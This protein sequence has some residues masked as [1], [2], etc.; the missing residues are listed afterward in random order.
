MEQIQNETQKELTLQEIQ[1]GSFQVLLKIKEICEKENIKYFLMY[2]TL[3]GAIRH[4][5]FI[6]WD[7]DIDVGMLRA[8]YERFIQYC[9]DHKE[10]IKPFELMHYRTNKKYIYP[11]AR[12]SDSRYRIEYNDAKDYGLGLFVDI[13]PFDKID[14]NDKRLIKEGKKRI[15]WICN[16]GCKH[17]IRSKNP[18]KTVLKIPF[19]IM[20]RFINLNKLLAKQDIQMQK[21][22][23]EAVDNIAISIWAISRVYPKDFCATVIPHVFNGSEFLIPEKYDIALTKCYG[24][25]MRL[26]PEE[27]RAGHHFYNAFKKSNCQ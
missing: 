16:C 17:L 2:G 8:D 20:S 27:E 18:I 1:Q 6:P 4:N 13:Y 15:W 7:D 5:G 10:E 9:I 11:I 26:P 12:L 19:Y 3:L 25:Y 22:E 21:Y 24:D 14:I 23:A